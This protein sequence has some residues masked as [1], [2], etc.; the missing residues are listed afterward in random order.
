[1]QRTNAL[2]TVSMCGVQG[3]GEAGLPPKKAGVYYCD[4][5]DVLQYFDALRTFEVRFL[6]HHTLS[7]LAH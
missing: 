5:G 3:F 4:Y 6:L 7:T 1:M 2:V